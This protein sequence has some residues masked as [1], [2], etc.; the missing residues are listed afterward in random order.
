MVK[1][2]YKVLPLQIIALGLCA[3]V[4]TS[5]PAYEVKTHEDISEQAVLQSGLKDF[6]PAI[7]LK[8]TNDTLVD[9]N[10]NKTIAEWIIQGANDEDDTIS[11]N[12]ARYRN[13]FFDPQHG[14]AG[15]SFGALTGEPS[16]DW[17]LE[18][19]RTFI[20]QSYSLRN[21]RQYFYDA[22]T[23]PSKDSR[24]MW[25]ARTFYTLGH[26]IHL[27]QDAAQPQHTRNDSHGGFGVGPRSRYELYTDDGDIRRT[28]PFSDSHYNFSNPVHFESARLFWATGDGR[29][30][31]EFSSLNFVT[32]GTNFDTDRYAFPRRTETTTNDENA[33]EL[34]QSIG[35]PIPA[36]CQPPNPPC[37]MTFYASDVNDRYRLAAS[38]VN[39]RTSTASIFDQD[40]EARNLPRTFSLNRFNFDEAHKFLIPRAVAYS[41]GLID[42]FFRGRLEAEDIE[43]TDTGIRLRV[44]NAID[45]QATPAWANE[46][47]YAI[48][49]AGAHGTFVVAFEY[50]DASGTMRYGVSSPVTAKTAAEG[51]GDLAPGQVSSSVY[52]F[53]LSLHDGVH[54]IKYRLVFRGKLGQEED[55]VAVGA[56]SPASGFVVIPSYVPVDGIDGRRLIHR[57]GGAW[58][59]SDRTNVVAGNV[60]WKGGYQ[61]GEPTKVLSWHGPKNRYFPDTKTFTNYSNQIF[62]NGGVFAVAPSPVLGAAI[63]VD[64]QG[65]E[66]LIAIC[67]ESGTVVYRRP[68]KKSDSS[69]LYH[70]QEQPDGW[71]EI[72]RFSSIVP[73]TAWFL[74]GQGTEAQTMLKKFRAVVGSNGRV[75]IEYAGLDRIKL[76]ITD[77]RV[78][79]ENFGNLAGINVSTTCQRQPPPTQSCVSFDAFLVEEESRQGEYVVAVDYADM[80]EK[81]G[82]IS[83]NRRRM[84]R[85]AMSRTFSNGCNMGSTMHTEVSNSI[86]EEGGRRFT[87]GAVSVDLRNEHLSVISD[88]V[89]DRTNSNLTSQSATINMSHE[90]QSR[91]VGFVDARYGLAAV[92]TVTDTYRLE[93][94]TPAGSV[95]HTVS[96]IASIRRQV[97][98]EVKS[99]SLDVPIFSSDASSSLQQIL[100]INDNPSITT[101]SPS[102]NTTILPNNTD[103][104]TDTPGSWA[105][106]SQNHMIISQQYKDQNWAQRYFNFLSGGDLTRILPDAPQDARYYPIGVVK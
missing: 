86:S 95:S 74:N 79:L 72:G 91:E 33:N 75:K 36:Q 98:A 55:A 106:D 48:N 45:T 69:A 38:R 12:F 57:S 94:F 77:D 78:T 11:T 60:D 5:L 71:Q 59:L 21:A 16:A 84:Y 15:Y 1:A 47:L 70:P 81:L 4:S 103:V 52:D 17:G 105:V 67:R 85:L 101:C 32:A 64:A 83:E 34:L 102:V 6:L 20:T 62:Q 29:G 68:N 56:I 80:E 37:V 41:A 51:G 31:A 18:D 88:T 65:K 28:L 39:P 61:N 24:E 58:K 73:D 100:G 66:W 9:I 14:G 10:V 7:G 96:G 49:S 97:G 87:M 104:I 54:D 35:K 43:F 25:M 99:T 23:L 13:H 44:K 53:N 19:T 89:T 42:Y 30:I 3:G 92:R 22:L 90:L 40:L 76:R 2:M 82:V 63:T 27:I 26:V 93:A 8:T 50:K 46:R